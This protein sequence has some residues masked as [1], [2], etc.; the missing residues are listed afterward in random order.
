[1]A[2][3]K[4]TTEKKTRRGRAQASETKD[5]APAETPTPTP[6]VAATP[7][8]A[9]PNPATMP[10]VQQ[11]ARLNPAEARAVAGNT[12]LAQMAGIDRKMADSVNFL[13]YLKSGDIAESQAFVL[14][15]F[16][17]V[18]SKDIS[19]EMFNAHHP[20]EQGQYHTYIFPKPGVVTMPMPLWRY[21]EAVIM[22]TLSYDPEVAYLGCDQKF[23]KLPVQQQQLIV[24]HL[25]DADM[26]NA[27]A[28][29]ESCGHLRQM[30]AERFRRI[31]NPDQ[32]IALQPKDSNHDAPKYK[33]GQYT[34]A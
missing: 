14:F 30:V 31:D 32:K 4:S 26:L 7:A 1:M 6:S 27:I 16:Q 21:F 33:P 5:P 25:W 8:P 11:V 29:S 15:K 34:P 2:E 10:G 12:A 24:Y 9:Q 22:P 3:S 18:D 13:D 28:G 20:D 19:P 17:G 23:T